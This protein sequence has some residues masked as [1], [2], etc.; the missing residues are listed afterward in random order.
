MRP[1]S[2]G[3]RVLGDLLITAGVI[4]ALFA[5]YELFYTGVYTAAAQSE[6][7]R[8]LT[9]DWATP[10]PSRS[11]ATTPAARAPAPKLGDGVA[12]LRIP[13]LGA[14][15]SEVVV[16]GVQVADLRKGPG[17]YPGTALPG[18]V[19]NFVVSGHRTTYGA[20]FG[21]LDRLRPT[22]PIVLE[23]RAGWYV[24]RVIRQQIVA[25]TAIN[26]I[27]PVPQHPGARPT[28]AM[29]TFTTCHPR[30]SARERLVVFGRLDSVRLRAAGPPPVLAG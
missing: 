23:T 28:Q 29:L 19:G 11:P 8:D 16:E 17:H 20:P 24:Y 22:D 6:L 27:D 3:L 1:A 14:N 4:V 7:R 26:V 10:T 12:I 2:A 25:P 21:Q 30:Y 9:R 18:R 5:G 15:Y 13:R